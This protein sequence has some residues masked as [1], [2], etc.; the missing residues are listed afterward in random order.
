MDPKNITKHYSNG[1]VTVVWQSARCQHS[2]NCFGNLPQVFK[3]GEYPWVQVANASTEEIIRTVKKC[4]SG[5]LTFIIN[6]Q[7]TPDAK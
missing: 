1:Q 4:P 5:A 7:E 6:E 3:P 2:G